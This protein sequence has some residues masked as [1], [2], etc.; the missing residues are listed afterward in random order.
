[1]V[2]GTLG[3]NAIAAELLMVEEDGCFWCEA[4][5]KD[6]AEIYPKTMEGK[7]APLRRVDIRT[8]LDSELD[9][10][11]SVHFT[12]TFLLIEDGKEIN[13]IEGYPGEDFFW[14][15]LGKML[16]QLPKDVEESFLNTS[17]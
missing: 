4:W 8:D 1:M 10:K 3:S 9:L 16:D 12:P 17:G 11:R 6:I 7:S 15:L 2:L 13:R 14:G 5:N